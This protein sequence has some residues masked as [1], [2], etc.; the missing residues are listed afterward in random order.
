[1]LRS[2]LGEA[3]WEHSCEDFLVRGL[4]SRAALAAGL[5]AVFG[6]EVLPPTCR[7]QTRVRFMRLLC[8]QST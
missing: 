4:C 5:A 7:V 3:T 8:L 6:W 1:M 2:T